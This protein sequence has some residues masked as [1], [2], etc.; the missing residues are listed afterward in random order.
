MSALKSAK[1]TEANLAEFL[2]EKGNWIRLETLRI[3]QAA[4]ETRVASS[5][6]NCEILAALYYGPI[7]KFRA[8]EPA[9]AERDRFVISKG[10]GSISMYPV[11]ADL[12]FIEK[13]ELETVCKSGSRLGG[14][15]DPIIPG[16]ETVNGSLG[17]G[18]GVAAG[19]AMGLR[20]LKR[21]ERVFTLA[22]DGELHE[23]AVWEAIMFAG[24]H[25]LENFHMIVDL[26]GKC[27]LNHT[28]DVINLEPLEKKF[29]AFGFTT[30]RVDGHN[31]M[32]VYEGLTELCE[33]KD[34][35]PKVLIAE[36]RKGK[37]VPKL[38]ATP[39]CHI[40]AL[41]EIEISEAIARLK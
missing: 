34:K 32:A 14:I 37:G 28:V 41:S 11:L 1:P 5:L 36:T 25:K 13:Q 2:A 29:E 9:W 20:T 18:V 4:R 35:R 8:D 19:M 12:G 17:H 38:E 22:G 40:V 10:H 23:G 6:S 24:H 27:M 39:H 16:F 26:N 33:K 7:L 3:H 30:A 15:P 21:S 31:A